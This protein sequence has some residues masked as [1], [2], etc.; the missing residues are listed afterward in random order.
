MIELALDFNCPCIQLANLWCKNSHQWGDNWN[1]ED[2]SLY[3]PDDRELPTANSANL[4]T[5]S[6]S[7]SSPSF[8][9]SR[10][11]S[12]NTRV[13]PQTLKQALSTPSISTESQPRS[14]LAEKPGYRAAEAYIR[15]GPVA[16]NGCLLKHN[17]DLKNCTFTLSLTGDAPTPEEAPT[18]IFLPEFHYPKLHIDVKAS[19]GKWDI[20]SKELESGTVQYLSWWHGEGD[21]NIRI[22]GAKRKIGETSNMAN[23]E[24]YLE[25]CQNSSC[26]IM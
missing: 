18:V 20:H 12:Q 22:Q 9:Q 8:S 19:G 5:A 17:F 15:P 16:I 6:L 1:G 21:Q 7:H 10:A 11:S 4:S 2:L 26:T 13:E 25:Q 23:D 14:I 3:S 24:G